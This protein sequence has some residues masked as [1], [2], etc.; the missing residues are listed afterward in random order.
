MTLMTANRLRKSFGAELCFQDVSFTL[1]GDDRIGLIGQNG[2][3]KTTFFKVLAGEE[4]AEGDLSRRRGLR[5]ARLEQ[6]PHF[7]AGSTPRSA[8]IE[9][10][11]HWRELDD[12]IDALREALADLS[13]DELDLALRRLADL[14]AKRDA[15]GGESATRRAL[16]MLRG[17]G[18]A[19]DQFDQDL[20]SMSGGE[21]CR[22]ALARLLFEEPD[23]WL[24][25]EPT[26][27]LDLA[28]IAFLERFLRASPAAAIVV[29][30]DRRFLDQITNATWE[31][32]GGRLFRYPGDYTTSRAI[33]EERRL[34]QWREFMKQREFLQREERFI[35]KWR[36]GTRSRQARS[37]MKRLS[38]LEL[39]DEPR[40]QSRLAVLNLGLSRRL[41]DLVLETKNLTVGFP[42]NTLFGGLDLE[43]APGEALGVVGPNGS[44]K[45]SLFATLLGMLPPLSGTCRWGP[46]VE[47]GALGQHEEFPDEKRTPLE[48]LQDRDLGAD[49]QD[50]RDKLGAMLFSGDDAYKPI[51]VLSGGEK[52]RLMLTRLLLEGHNVLL[53]DEPTNHLDIQ[54]SE[55][56][57]LALT[58]Y[59]GT[60]V[61]ISHDRYFLDDIADRVLWL[62]DGTWRIT[63]GGFAEAAA[64]REASAKDGGGARQPRSKQ[65]RRESNGANPYSGWRVGKL[66][67]RIIENEERVGEIHAAFLDPAAVKDGNHMRRLQT[68]LAR[69]E[70]EQ[71]LLESEYARRG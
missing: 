41:G 13:G 19:E 3:G 14:E 62:E 20:D 70:S 68:E 53:L 29:S 33:R 47:I 6:T 24:L 25:D 16:A 43:L 32:E 15:G 4:D 59:M 42:D 23:L 1:S 7:P 56:V 18:I 66:E 22:V 27:H 63:P 44:G 11:G 48:Y 69:I 64:E 60:V 2:S 37:R 52:K 45:S 21:R 36:A 40:N 46:T 38:R 65:P 49:D 55:A 5:I 51:A 28:G 30:H 35:D 54:S 8:M 58:A 67:K 61:V 12:D 10:V 57:T 17:V 71:A 50:R 26:N 34:A 9:A 39:V 31:L